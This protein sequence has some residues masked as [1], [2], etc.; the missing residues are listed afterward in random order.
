MLFIYKSIKRIKKKLS[1]LGID[2]KSRIIRQC[3][4]YL[5]DFSRGDIRSLLKELNKCYFKLEIVYAERL[6]QNI[7]NI[8]NIFP[9][10]KE[11]SKIAAVL[12]EGMNLLGIRNNIDFYI[13]NILGKG[14]I[15]KFNL[16]KKA[17]M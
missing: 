3:K 10:L 16:W 4:L 15:K 17:S 2:V 12:T 1:F 13:I 9:Q 11:N 14:V 6:K 5:E 8:F 7:N